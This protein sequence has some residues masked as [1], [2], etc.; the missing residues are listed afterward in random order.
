[1]PFKTGGDAPGVDYEPEVPAEWDV[2][3]ENVQ[4][5][6]DAIA[7]AGGAGG[8]DV[9]SVNGQ[10]GTV[11]LD[12]GDVG[13]DPTGSASGAVGDHVAASNPHPQY[14][15]TYSRFFHVGTDYVT[16]QAAVNAA[17][18]LLP[19]LDTACLILIPP[20]YWDESVVVRRTAIDLFGYGGQAIT[21]LRRLTYT[22]ATDAS[23]ATYDISD[24]PADL[25]AQTQVGIPSN[26]QVRGLTLE[27]RSN[28]QASL[29]VLGAGVGTL[30]LGSEL[31]LELTTIWGS[32]S[33]RSIDAVM[34]NY[35]STGGY[36]W[37]PGSIRLRNV[38]GFWPLGAQIDGVVEVDYDSAAA[39]GEPNDTG[40]YGLNGKGSFFNALITLL[41]EGRIGGGGMPTDGHHIGAGVTATGSGA[42]QLRGGLLRGTVNLGAGTALTHEAGTFTG[43]KV[44]T[45]TF[46]RNAELPPQVNA[47]SEGNSGSTSA[48]MAVKTS[49]SYMPFETGTYRLDYSAEIT[50]GTAMQ[51]VEVDLNES[52]AGLGVQ[53]SIRLEIP[54]AL[55]YYSFA[56]HKVLSL[57][58]ATA[59][60]FDMRWRRPSA[61]GTA[62]IMRA[63]LAL[64]R[65]A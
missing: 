64:V 19:T 62:Y 59:Y 5:A 24:D 4:E 58:T 14:T 32:T 65:I 36:C 63:R 41:N 37:I 15:R 42:S 9:T 45:G 57:T 13:A 10:V 29:R 23:I 60:Q 30:F 40:N 26:N 34:A 21:T 49:L 53:A 46:T 43:T 17:E 33:G 16:I 54:L 3:P 20:G 55:G 51:Q 2:P 22:N 44:G 28:A 52:L 61:A 47:A 31:L 56:G 11:V 1:M 48:T 38:A 27:E 39:Y 12:A 50:Q 8:G 6:L 7:S 25:I 18:L 35:I